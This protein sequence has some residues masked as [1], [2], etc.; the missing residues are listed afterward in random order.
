MKVHLQQQTDTKISRAIWHEVLE[1]AED[2]QC[3]TGVMNNNLRT[4]GTS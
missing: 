3:W 4:L 2:S 1:T